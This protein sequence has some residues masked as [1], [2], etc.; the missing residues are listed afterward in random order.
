MR[1]RPIVIAAVVGALLLRSAILRAWSGAS[2]VQTVV[3]LFES[4]WHPDLPLDLFAAGRLGLIKPTWSD[5]YRYVAY[6]WIVGLGFNAAEQ[7]ALVSM[8]NARLGLL[9]PS[10]TTPTQ[11]NAQV[12]FGINATTAREVAKASSE[13]FAARN[14]VPD[15]ES[16][17]TIDVFRSA[18]TYFPPGTFKSTFYYPNCNAST[19]RTAASTLQTMIGKFGLASPEVKGWVAA[20]D[21]VFVN[22]SGTQPRLAFNPET[23]GKAFADWSKAINEWYQAR[24]KVPG[25][26]PMPS[27]TGGCKAEELRTAATAL[28]TMIG[29]QGV[30]SPQVKQW[31]DAQD[32]AFEKCSRPSTPS[33]PGHPTPAPAPDIPPPLA[34]ATPFEQAQRTYQ[35]ACANFYAG[36]FEEATQLFD[37][38]AADRSSPW[39]EWAPYLAARATVRTATLSSTKNDPTTLA[40]A[41]A[42]LK[43]I[44]AAPGGDGVNPPAQRLLSFVEFRLHP[45]Q[46]VEEVVRALMRPVSEQTLAQDLSDYVG[47]WGYS[48]KGADDFYADDLTDWLATFGEGGGSIYHSLAQWKKTASLPWLVAA[49]SVVPGSDAN[50]PALIEAAGKV[51]PDSPA[52]VTVTFHAA[53]LLMEQ[54]KVDEARARLDTMLAMRGALPRS[55]INELAQLRMRTARNLDE[56]FSDAQRIPLGVTDTGDG[57]E[58]PSNV[59]VPWLSG[60]RLKELLAAPLFDRDGAEV[61]SRWVP[62]SIQKRA[63]QSPILR[64]GLRGQV[65]LAAWTRAILLGDNASAREL[66]PAVSELIPEL[67][68]SANAW[69]TAQDPQARRFEA[70]FIMLTHPGM[71]P[72]VDAGVGRVTPLDQMDSLRDNWW[73]FPSWYES[74]LTGG[75]RR[76]PPSTYPLF[77]SAA[78]RKS[79]DEQWQT[80]STIN[81][82]NLLCAE[83]IGEA[84]RSPHDQRIPEA[85]YLC[86]S[87]VHL[88]CSSDQGTEYAKSAY[89]LLHR[90]YPE[91]P[92]AQKN[93][94]WYRGGGCIPR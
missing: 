20:Q 17:D 76:P 75:G 35:I 37:A 72:Y 6:R 14:R 18:T 10:E 43:V 85:L 1:R 33:M 9:P 28:E 3:T 63:A 46:R 89:S 79:A 61:L 78:Q 16:L 48:T 31:L 80:L 74:S 93:R 8:W 41:E 36:N 60:S 55:T 67:R 71:R 88:G 12:S 45:E 29:N 32:Q 70:A 11:P 57:D 84:K 49:I 83:A 51:K 21:Q 68:P 30:A 15:V 58:L 86:I 91:N 81:A 47:M 42:Q 38:I 59:D 7:K 13:W 54:G 34:H 23:W 5:S 56:L 4:H 24:K 39:H 94:F 2:G 26:S 66:A 25:V 22:C 77:L 90:R 50:A 40:Q 64:S 44:I 73:R 62:L 82:P 92:W 69:L 19:F 87:A 65:A 27:L 53:R 52:Y